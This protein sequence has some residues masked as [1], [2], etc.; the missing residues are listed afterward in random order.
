MGKA[1]AMAA[2]PLGTPQGLA[3]A[4]LETGLDFEPSPELG[5]WARATFIT[6]GAP[7]ENPDH[8][9]LQ[10]ASL[11]MLFT[12]VVNGRA[13]R[14]V[15]GQCEIMPPGVVGKWARARAEQ[16]I[17]GWFGGL[18]HFLLTFDAEY[19]AQAGD[20]E[21]CALVEHE[22]YHAGQERDEFGLP[23]FRKSGMP[24]F[25]IRGHDVEEFVGV[26]ARYGAEAAGVRAMVEAAARGPTIA[27]AQIGH[28][29]GTCGVRLA[30]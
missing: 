6:A 7:L 15:I 20:A 17:E 19:L 1:R 26:V 4:M 10:F 11:G 22:L 8:K 28:A 5:E 29:C 13:G 18:P 3:R 16:Q 2:P 25:A 21:V 23:K 24:A 30:A 14:Q 9:H 27:P 12:R